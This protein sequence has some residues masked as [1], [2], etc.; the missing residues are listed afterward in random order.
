MLAVM[1]CHA[2]GFFNI[3]IVFLH[4]ASYKQHS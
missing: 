1:N 4:E 3:V 2:G